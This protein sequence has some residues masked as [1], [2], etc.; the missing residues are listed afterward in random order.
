MSQII[1]NTMV[2]GYS[3]PPEQEDRPD[4]LCPR[5]GLE[6][7]ND[8][9]VYYWHDNWICEECKDDIGEEWTWGIE[10]ASVEDIA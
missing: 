8:D 5:C 7:Y 9:Q 10:S 3:V 1:E 4:Y 6:M 2:S